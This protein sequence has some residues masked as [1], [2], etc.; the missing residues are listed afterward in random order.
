MKRMLAKSMRSVLALLLVGCL[1]F[2][3]CGTALAAEAECPTERV[4]EL[5]EELAAVI[6]EYV[7]KALQNSYDFAAA[8]VDPVLDAAAALKAKLDTKAEIADVLDRTVNKLAKVASTVDFEEVEATL[9][10][11]YEATAELYDAVKDDPELL[12][13]Y[14]QLM[15]EIENLITFFKLAYKR[16]T[17]AD[18]YVSN[19]T[20]Y[21]AIGDDTA[22]AE[23]DE[24]SYVDKLAAELEIKNVTN[25]ADEDMMVEDAYDVI[26]ENAAVVKAADLITV[27]F[28]CNNFVEFTLDKVLAGE[29]DVG[30]WVPYVTEAGAEAIGKIVAELKD[31]F[32]Q[33]GL[34]KDAYTGMDYALILTLAIESYAYSCAAYAFNMPLLLNDISNMNE[35]AVVVIVGMY[36]PLKGVSLNVGGV[37][38]PMGIFVETL[39]ETTDI[40]NLTYAMLTCNGI[41]ANMGNNVTTVKGSA[42]L[43]LFDLIN[44]VYNGGLEPN[45]AGHTEIKDRIM[46][47]LRL[48]SILYGDVDGDGDVDLRDVLMLMQYLNNKWS[49]EDINEPACYLDADDA[50]TLRD[51]L[52]LM[53]FVNHKHASLPLDV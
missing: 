30:D 14:D 25:L 22:A 46:D 31:E 20:S 51:L 5:I 19:K 9:E 33:M 32:T 26:A 47:C 6:M 7:P 39:V 15:I 10:E 13:L 16:A 4:E 23:K 2:G 8:Q 36:N 12:A 45:A 11:A 42:D 28:N 1:V 18:L 27:G 37:S 44:T 49:I 35:D 48:S 17:S 34:G 24:T 29:H 3:M 41:F 43:A 21:V 38:I 40:Y 50:I 53:Q 52:I